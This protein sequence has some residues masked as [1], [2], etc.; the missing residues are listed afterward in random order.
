[1]EINI[2]IPIIFNY[3]YFHIKYDM[4]NIQYIYIF[5]YIIFTDWMKIPGYYLM[6]NKNGVFKTIKIA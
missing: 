2:I 3:E 6:L 4:I 5:I 1:M